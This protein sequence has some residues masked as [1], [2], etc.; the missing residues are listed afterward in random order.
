MV[1][2]TGTKEQTE[3]LKD[4]VAQ[5]KRQLQNVRGGQ[6]S[7]ED[8]VSGTRRPIVILFETLCVLTSLFVC[9]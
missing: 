1:V 8:T 3:A 6:L 9:V 4:E 2:V 5:L 7:A